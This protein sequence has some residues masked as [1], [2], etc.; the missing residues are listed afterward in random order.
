[1]RCYQ[2]TII[3][4][5][6]FVRFIFGVQRGGGDSSQPAFAYATENDSNFRAFKL[7]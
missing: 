5:K 3:I 2:L 6:L 1:M 7:S 4:E